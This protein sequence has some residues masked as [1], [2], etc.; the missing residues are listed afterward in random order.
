MPERRAAVRPPR[1]FTRTIGNAR[2]PAAPVGT[3]S[4]T[5]ADLAGLPPAAAR[6]LRAMGVVGRPRTWSLRAHFTGRFR[7]GP[8]QPWMPCDAWQYN[9]AIEVARLFRMRLVFARVVPMWGWD[10]YRYGTGR[11]LGKLLN[12]VTVADGSGPEFDTS[13]LVTWLND[14]VLLAPG[15]LLTPRVAWEPA[16]DDGFRVSVSDAG[17]TVGADVVLDD[18]GRPRDFRTDDRYADLPGG[19]VRAP[20]STPVPAWDV[21]DGRPRPTAGAAVWHLPDGEFRYAELRLADLALDVP[22]GR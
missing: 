1:A 16:G 11:M 6:Y 5:E 18:V 12:L 21:V 10:T 9:S 17:R 4:V 2:L 8:D 14:A 7:R 19:L 22:A 3:A 15:M 13:E 20:W